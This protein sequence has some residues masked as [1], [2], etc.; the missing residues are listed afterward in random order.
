[1]DQPMIELRVFQNV[2]FRT[3]MAVMLF[4]YVAQFGRLVYLPLQLEGLRGE[5]A[6]TVGLLFM[7]AGVATAVAMSIG[8]RLVDARG[9]RYPVMVG[10]AAMFLAMVG[11]AQLTLT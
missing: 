10:C 11:F 2:A 8:G 9:P 1:T 3:A 6:L 4:L 7:P 5:T